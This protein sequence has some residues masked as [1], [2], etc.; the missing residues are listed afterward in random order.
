MKIKNKILV[1][2][3][4]LFIFFIA[5]IGFISIR[6]LNMYL[7]ENA[8]NEMELR[9]KNNQDVYLNKSKVYSKE[10]LKLYSDFISQTLS[11]DNIRVSV[12]DDTGL[13][14]SA[15]NGELILVNNRDYGFDKDV[16]AAFSGRGRYKINDNV[17]NYIVPIKYNNHVLG[18]VEYKR[19]L[20]YE[21]GIIVYFEKLFVL[22]SLGIFIILVLVSVHISKI[23]TKPLEQLTDAAA[24][25]SEG[26]LIKLDESSKDET[27]VLSSTFNMMEDK[28]KN[29]IEEQKVFI[30]NASHELKTP[31]TSILGYAEYLKDNQV[32]DKDIIDSLYNDAVRMKELVV[33]LLEISRLGRHD[34]LIIKENVDISKLVTEVI[35]AMQ[36]KAQKFNIIIQHEIEE[37]VYVAVDS[38]KILQVIINLVDNAIKYSKPNT[39][40]YVKLYRAEENCC[41]EITDLGIGIPESEINN[42]FK[43]FYRCKNSSGIG[44]NGLGL[45]IVEEIVEAHHG[46]I[47]VES[48]VD[49]GTTFKVILPIER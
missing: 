36:F 30:D 28:I 14:S 39:T 11:K 38:K 25:F 43:R 12:Y 47:I 8:L 4:L 41:I 21:S 45:S 33:E 18:A 32:Y 23:I 10:S 17:I 26:E 16:K 42:I 29:Q 22:S 40:V 19:T 37:G 46:N 27:G 3:S 24:K 44:G 35:D 1:C 13:L 2:Y 48:S 20:K 15:S 31:V 7:T 9:V 5:S 49:K 6:F 34:S